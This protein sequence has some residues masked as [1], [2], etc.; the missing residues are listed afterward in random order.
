MRPREIFFFLHF[1]NKTCKTG[2]GLNYFYCFSLG[3]G[4]GVIDSYLKLFM[5]WSHTQILL[6]LLL[7][8][9]F[10]IIILYYYGVCVKY[11]GQIFEIK[12]KQHK[13]DSC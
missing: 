3:E 12:T 11:F 1:Q 7:C 9:M 8:K 10:V 2:H 6:S 5:L 13:T 4:V